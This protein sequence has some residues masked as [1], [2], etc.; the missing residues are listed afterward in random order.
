VNTRDTEQKHSEQQDSA[1]QDSGQQDS[2]QQDE[3]TV[4]APDDKTLEEA[5]K[6][7]EMYEE[8]RPTVVLPGSDGTISGTAINDW[9]DDDG[10]PIDH[11]KDER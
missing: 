2:G 5:R 9:L 3:G 10:N 1:Q 7:F 8:D 4:P 11:G 6:T